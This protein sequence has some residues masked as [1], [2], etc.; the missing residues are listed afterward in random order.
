MTDVLQGL[1]A[2]PWA[3]LEHAYGSA[4]DVPGLL[5][6][7]LAPNPRVRGETLRTLYSNVFHQGS[8][9]PATAHVIPFLIEMCASPAVPDRYDL[10]RYWGSLI[11][12]YFSVLARPCWGDGERIH[13]NGQ[14]VIPEPGDSW[15]GD[16]PATLHQVY[17]ESVK[18]H[19]VA[20]NLL[21]DDN[22]AVRAGAAWVLACLPTMAQASVPILQAQLLA[23]PSGWVRAAIAF[24]LGEL[25]AAA[26][27]RGV[28]S[29]DAFP[30][31]RCMAACQL[32]RIEPAE[33][34]MGPLLQFVAAPIE[35]Y[36]N[37]PGAGGKSTGD[38]AFSISHLPPEVQ[39]RAIPTI[40]DRL[41]QARSF[42]T[43]PLAGSLLAA[44]FPR[45]H[46]AVTELTAL[47]REVLARMVNTEE[48]WS[49]GNLMWTFQAYG[50]P[51]DREKCAQLVG[52]KVAD[53][54]ALKTLSLGLAFADIGF[55]D[56]G[57]EGILE[58]LALD[59]AVFERAPAPEECWLLCAKAFAESDPE[60]ALAAYR[61][62]TAL[63]PATAH[64]VNPTWRLA[65][66]LKEH[67]LG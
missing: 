5:R 19:E 14:V 25:G 11:T 8:R 27:L 31:A 39:R 62:A 9:Y 20:C 32:A 50:L 48:L 56:K 24:A 1:D 40:C 10:L 12:G 35:G 55:L 17:R 44:A 16:Y 7:L 37:I 28:L 22:H 15:W 65:D 41:D 63:N 33:A 60:R 38:A 30:A 54:E 53:D 52:V 64:R 57:R 18:G 67:G 21:A 6:K 45:R 49:I 3:D 46:D 34:L 66:L 61:R 2:V 51:W 42:D 58:A 29:D 43:M 4:A 59:P 13:D 26:P 47:Q 36:E 23:E